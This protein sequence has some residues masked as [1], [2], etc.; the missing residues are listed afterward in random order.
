MIVATHFLRIVSATLLAVILMLSARSAGATTVVLVPAGGLW[1]FLDDGSNQGTA[2]RGRLFNDSTWLEGFAQLGYGEFDEETE[3][4]FG[5]AETDKFIT[6]YFRSEF[7]VD[8]ASSYFG[9]N[10]KVLR[11]DGAVVYLNGAE[12]YRDNLPPGE[13]DYRTLAVTNVSGAAEDTFYEVP[14]PAGVLV[15]GVNVLAVEVHQSLPTSAD[16]SFDLELTGE[17]I[18]LAVTRGPYLQQ[19]STS[20]IIVRW[21]TNI[22][23]DSRVRF[24]PD[25]DPGPFGFI[26]ED[27]DPT[28]EHEVRL[29]GLTADTLY[30][31][32]IGTST[33][34]LAGGDSCLFRTAPVGAKPTRIWVIGDSGTAGSAARSVYDAYRSFNAETYADVWLMLGD[35]AYGSGTDDEYQRAVFD[36]YPELLRKTVLWSTIGNHETYSGTFSDFAFLHIFNQPVD[37]RCGGVPSGTE[38]YFSFDYGNIHFVCLD[39]MTSDR[40]SNAP[41]C[42]WLRADLAANTQDWLIAFWHHPPYTKGSHDSDWEYEL[43]QMRENAVPILES[44]GVDLV[45]CGH[46]H[47]YERS[48]LIDGHYGLSDTFSQSMKKDAS[49]GR[50]DQ[51]GPYH[52]SVF[53]PGANQG[54]VYIVAGSS[55]Q[56]SGGWLDHP[57]MF[58]GQLTLG[59]L[60]LDVDGPVLEAKFLRETGAIDDYF[61]ITKGNFEFPL[62][63]FA[64][65]QPGGAVTLTWDTRPGKFYAVEKS[66]NLTQPDWTPVDASVKGSGRPMSLTTGPYFG[67][68]EG[69]TVF[70]RV[71][72]RDPE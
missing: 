42:N 11:D 5:P 61:T 32:S 58:F 37:G 59:S 48:F 64:R 10:L 50:A 66:W 35:N 38:K 53:G 21:R 25:G 39:A 67:L 23:T 36:M 47:C 3:L 57:A 14:V 49:S 43:I 29:T 71:V 15:E 4:N 46:S 45:L 72:E 68:G 16:L 41:M 51:T 40:S 34:V 56:V 70:F 20:N 52:K 55:G 17:S 65:I 6:Y 12:I 54:A 19:G 26:A 28:L 31:Y 1:R 24:A 9:L 63:L 8:D 22:P 60:V 2:W 7:T 62:Q 27:S 18:P 13:M 69:G 33:R 44:Y 30:Y